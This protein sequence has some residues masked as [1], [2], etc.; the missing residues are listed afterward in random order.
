MILFTAFS[1]RIA[2]VLLELEIWKFIILRTY[3]YGK[4]SFSLFLC[5]LY[6]LE[7]WN[8]MDT[9]LFFTEIKL[10]DS[11]RI[12]INQQKLHNVLW[13]EKKALCGDKQ[14]L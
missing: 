2:L 6:F 7:N 3:T 8:L 5:F 11:N 9:K 1:L 13:H 14:W 4:H 10:F 12:S